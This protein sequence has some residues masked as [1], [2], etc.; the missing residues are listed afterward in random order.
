MINYERY[1]EKLE[2]I[3]N[4][5]NNIAVDI[6]TNEIT[7]CRGLACS[8]CLFSSDNNDGVSCYTNTIKWLLAEYKEP[9]VDWSKVPI[10]TPVLI[11]LD[12]ENWS[13]RYF[14][15]VNENGKPMVFTNGAT[16]W[17]N[18]GDVAIDTYFRR[19]KLTEVS[20]EKRK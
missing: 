20:D 5:N 17:S 9:E 6:D 13:R 7:T 14:A 4:S 1:K 12:N 10:D 8:R 16:Q 19:I 2:I 11:S 18:E 15:G 3:L